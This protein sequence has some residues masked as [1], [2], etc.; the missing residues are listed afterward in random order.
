M[1][2][3]VVQ[4]NRVAEQERR[5]IEAILRSRTFQGSPS[6]LRL[7]TYIGEQY[8]AGEAESLKEYNIAIDVLGKP[9]DF[10]TKRDSIVRVEAYRLRK[11]LKVYYATE[12]A[13]HDL[14]MVLEPGGYVPK[15]AA[16][17]PVVPAPAVDS[18]SGEGE[19]A[20]G[21]EP[22]AE[23]R[24]AP[25]RR[26][27]GPGPIA[28]AILLGAVAWILYSRVTPPAPPRNV[29]L[30][31]TLAGPVVDNLGQPW[32]GDQWFQGGELV[33]LASPPFENDSTTVRFS[34]REGDFNYD[35][36]LQDGVYEIKFYFVADPRGRPFTRRFHV[37]ANGL[38]LI[39]GANPALARPF[40][41][42]L[43]IGSF[44]DIRPARD[45][46]LHLAFRRGADPA[47]VAAIELTEGSAG[48]LLPIRILAKTAP[49]SAPDGTMWGADRY[50]AGGKL[51][52]RTEPV[53]G[54]FNPNL[55]ISERY[56]NFAY[57]IPVP[58]GAYR[59]T[60][61]MAETWFGPGRVGG[62]GEGSRRFDV[63]ANGA[64]LLT[65]FDLFREA[66]GSYI[67]I[68][69]TFAHLTPDPD[70]YLNLEFRARTNNACVNAIEVVEER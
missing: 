31:M 62:G 11:K 56:G 6:V 34:R 13:G 42:A 18:D 65:D 3:G 57:R 64:A 30:M 4:G 60:L 2:G 16:R 26:V 63:L 7:A 5:E 39:D 40:P 12:G 21:L 36:P 8:L 41:E 44:R 33:D 58:P 27:R 52:A 23:E 51:V 32:I 61:Y 47:Q 55:F 70:G 22:D 37:F 38:Q 10:D 49:Y 48:K 28:A 35:I 50:S 9:R 66:G 45:G 29:R 43:V 53:R 20:E 24:A 25:A 54:A 67:G 17:T 14:E 69:R 15:F 1:Q 59:V 19:I 46:K 68:A